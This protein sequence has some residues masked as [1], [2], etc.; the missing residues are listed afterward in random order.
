M[1]ERSGALLERKFHEYLVPTV[2]MTIAISVANV[3]NSIVVGNF[4][5]GTALSA[6]GLCAPI[7]YSLNAVYLLFAVGGVTCASIAKG[8]REEEGANR[9]FTLTFAAGISAMLVLL[10]L[11]LAFIEPIAL[12]LA[13]GDTGLAELARAYLLPLLFV[14]PV[15]MLIMGMAQFART[16]GK[17]R[18][19]AYI[20]VSANLI[21]LVLAFIFIRFLGAGIGGAGWATVLG[22]SAGVFMLLPYLLSKQRTLNFV[23]LRADDLKLLPHIVGVGSPK[24]LLQGL[25]FLRTLVLN[26]L[27]VG[28]LGTTGMA[29]MTVCVNAL[30]LASMFISGSTDTLL[31]IVGTLYG[32][33]DIP[34]IRFTVRTGFRFMLAA[35]L[36]VMALFLIM[37]GA[38]GRMFG[39]NT[40]QSL[41]VVEPSLRMYA[42]SLPLYGVNTMLQSFYQTTGRVKLASI[43]VSLNGFVFVTLFALLLAGWN[44]SLIW[45]A[46]VL[47][48]AAAFIAAMCVGVRIR[49]REGAHGILLL[50]KEAQDVRLDLSIPATV[51]AASGLSEQV[52]AFC[53][54]NGVDEFG[55]MRV[56][57]AV[58]EMAANTA[59]YGHKSAKG[60]IDAL[61]RIAQQ[62]IIL[63]LRDDGTPFDPTKYKS[64]E[65]EDFAVGGI[66][67]VRRLAKD[68]SYMRQ[69]GFNVTIIT[70]PRVMLKE[71]A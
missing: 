14:G 59:R 7:A 2:L 60:M 40:P 68:I 49:K 56:G 65:E 12:A 69:V 55:A 25:S 41:A 37:P 16:D 5:G 23:A 4:L 51:E 54:E 64:G 29:A 34:G 32:E 18:V 63:R 36:A 19:A 17:P 62:E 27:I 35:C 9:I 53:R 58:E 10:G 28:A 52:I 42:L 48:E 30:M 13:Q 38:V 6:M 33:R 57:I 31:P 46:F 50:R 39:I 43:L 67:V 24:A 66:E 44:A 22:Y 20:A 47:A 61:V 21:N 45:L 15:M 71:E 26:A 8:R 11:L 1:Y 3:V 70:V